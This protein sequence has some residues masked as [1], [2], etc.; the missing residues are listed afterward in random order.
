VSIFIAFIIIIALGFGVYLSVMPSQK[1]EFSEHQTVSSSSVLRVSFPEEMNHDSVDKYLSLP[2]GLSVDRTWQGNLLLLQPKEKLTTG[3]TYTL[4]LDRQVQRSDGTPLGRELVYTFVVAGA[5]ILS[6]QIPPSD[7]KNVPVSTR[8]AVVF[9]RPIVP[10]K[11]VQGGGVGIAGW[12]PTI[13]P[14]VVGRWRWLGTTTA[15]FVPKNALKLATKYMVTIPAGLMTISGDPTEKEFTW[16]FETERPRVLS[17]LPQE[18]S[19]DAGPTTMLAISFNHEMDLIS[20]KDSIA[21]RQQ[22]T[23]KEGETAVGVASVQYGKKEEGKKQVTDKTTV[24]VA[25]KTPFVFN[26]KYVVDLKSGIRGLEGALGSESGTTFTFSTVG[27]FQ[28]AEGTYQDGRLQVKFSNPVNDSSLKGNIVFEPAVDLGD[29][30]FKTNEWNQGKVLEFYPQLKPSTKY[31]VTVKE[32]VADAYGQ[33]LVKPFNFSFK[34]PPMQSQVFL[35]PRGNSFSIF[36]RGKPPIY[37]INNVNVSGLDVSLG[38][39]SLQRFLEIRGMRQEGPETPLDLQSLAT[40][41]RTWH[42]SPAAGKDAWQNKTF[43]IEKELN[44][45]LKPGIYAITLDTPEGK[46]L[47]QKYRGQ[48]FDDRFFAITDMGLTLKFSGGKVL[49]WVTNLETGDPVSGAVIAL[50][51]VAGTTPIVSGKTDKDGFF[52]SKISIADFKSRSYDW[53]PEFWVTAT[54]GDDFAFVSSNWNNGMQPYDF[55]GVY[56]DFRSPE[57]NKVR[58]QSYVYTERPVYR[59]GDTVHFKA[60]IRYLDW[61]GKYALP[62]SGKTVSLAIQDPNGKEVYRKQLKISAFGSVADSFPVAKE[63]PLGFYTINGQLVPDTDVGSQGLWGNFSV[64]AYRKPE[65]RVTVTPT[66]EE[67]FNNDTVRADISGQYYF[68]APMAGASV[69]WRATSTD[70]FFNKYTEGWYS[71]ALEDAWCWRN[72]DRSTRVLTEGEGKLDDAG[73]LAVS[74]KANIDDRSVSQVVSIEADITDKNNQVVSG[75]TDAIVH[76]SKV[77]V[78]LKTQDY[79][80]P[81]GQEAKVDVITLNPDGTKAAGKNVELKLYSRVWNTVKEKGVDGEYYYDNQPT[82][83]YIRSYSVR[84]DSEGK[85]VIPVLLDKGGEFRAVGIVKDDA[86]REAKAGVGL[87]AWSDTYVNWSHSNNDRMEIIADKPTYN[88]GDTAKLLV[89]TPYQGKGVKAL[90]TVERENVITKSVVDVQSNALPV[91]VPITDDLV[92]TA[93]VSVVVMKPRMGETFDDKNVDTGAP[94][95]KIGYIKLPIDT[96]SRELMVKVRTDKERYLPGEKVT[97]HLESID[98]K[99]VPVSAELS[100][101]VVDLSILDLTGFQMPD[102]VASFYSER[103]LGVVTAN[104]L[105]QLMERFK[106]GSKGGGGGED[107]QNAKRGNFLDTAY[108]NPSIITDKNGQATVDFTLPD[109]LTT[110]HFLAM[111]STKE[112]LFG[113]EKAT[114]I[115]TKNVI[116]RPVRPRFAVAGDR[117]TLGAIVHNYLTE[118]RS[119]AVSLTGNG[120]TL[121]GSDSRTVSVPKDGNVKVDFSVRIADTEN[122]TMQFSAVAGDARDIVEETIPV[123][124]FGV[125][126]ANATSGETETVTKEAVAIPNASDAS[127]GSLSVGLS[128]SL[129]VYLPK[130]LEYLVTFPYGCAEQTISSLIPNIALKQLAGFEQFAVYDNAKLEKAILS[131][132]QRLYAFQRGDGGFGYWEGTGKSYPALTAYI[133]S[134]LKLTND[135]GYAVDGGVRERARNYLSNQLH[136][137]Q[138]GGQLLD[139]VLRAYV[140]FV[141]GE[142]GTVDVALL[143]NLYTKRAGLPL[144]AKAHLAMAYQKAGTASAGKRAKELLLDILNHARIDDRGVQIKEEDNGG[145]REFMQ[146]DDRTNALVLQALVRIDP[147]NALLPKLVRGMLAAR[148]D[149]HWDTTQSTALSILSFVE[150]LKQSQE[151]SY[152]FVGA[153]EIDGKKVLEQKFKSAGP[154]LR[155]EVTLALTSLDRGKTVDVNVGKEGTGKLYYD[156]LLSYFYTPD[157]ID[158]AEEGIGILRETT[159]LTKGQIGLQVGETYKVKLTITV[160]VT[161][162]F[163]AVESPLPAGLEPIDLQFQTSQQNLLQDKTNVVEDYYQSDLWRFSHTELRDDRVFLFADELPAGVYT[164]EYL[165]RATTPGHFRERP[166][167]V[168]EMYFP[169]T[170]GQTMG[171]WVD[172]KE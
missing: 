143:D 139:P 132:L 48:L 15:E 64:L 93:Y 28:V 4:R 21:L 86:G 122:V 57:A 148:T 14:D 13:S 3:K 76:K 127:T 5:P 171:G 123:F 18:G 33:K 126:Q 117:I 59:A 37:Y 168:W 40:D 165:V 149:G 55:S 120:F 65:Y 42:F 169:E 22:L 2:E 87:Y 30:D 81:T 98:A 38:A 39:L 138:K 124:R 36:E 108:W 66:A 70:Y 167:R 160:P 172:V 51:K 125:Q 91:E 58:L 80:V 137:D 97:V 63:A 131:G 41:V 104:M 60:L 9:D 46:N 147:K 116:L 140:L 77:Y 47:T 110:W 11:Q 62:P 1:F 78:G 156:V 6:V 27:A 113:Q 161:R 144:F 31:T 153:A 73:K 105:T 85:G 32:A 71:F 152:D 44:A 8:I 79:V 43:D 26:G 20:I 162:H 94:A 24:V 111:G 114:V 103:G 54:K 23:G 150:Y 99:G 154:L 100:L 96:S 146:T 134:A 83:T 72:C 92:P 29:S 101:G 135:A 141:L 107:G 109:N 56:S 7:G 84:T 74:F 166:A 102:L 68:G 82:D 35:Y 12:A 155:K 158:P 164:Y 115:E 128:P 67:Y 53:Q 49:V 90:V 119:F 95:F 19:A 118:D 151:L 121:D 52:E 106:P 45:P 25:P 136:A 16:S 10:L 17:T 112:H 61:N 88:V 145:F 163:V 69:K 50:Y 157:I 129:G 159:P 130:G 133:L 89:K 170:F 34:T 75:R 142:E